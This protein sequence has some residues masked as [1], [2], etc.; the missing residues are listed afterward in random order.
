VS[1]RG[2]AIKVEIRDAGKGISQFDSKKKM[3][4]RVGVGVQGMQERV[5]QLQGKFEIQSG[6]AGTTIFV[7]LPAQRRQDPV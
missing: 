3:P 1:Y 4:A 5:R 6:A 7:T 2:R